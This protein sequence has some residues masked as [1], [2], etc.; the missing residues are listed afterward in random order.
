MAVSEL[1]GMHWGNLGGSLNWT[2]MAGDNL[3]FKTSVALTRF[4]SRNGSGHN[5]YE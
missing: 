1:M 2:A 4:Q 3:S 5:G